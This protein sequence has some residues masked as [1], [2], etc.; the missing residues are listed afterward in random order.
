MIDPAL[1]LLLGPPGAALVTGLACRR[2]AVLLWLGCLLV[3]VGS[4]LLVSPNLPLLR[5]IG[6]MLPYREYL[7]VLSLTAS[8]LPTGL[9]LLAAGLLRWGRARRERRRAAKGGSPPA[10]ASG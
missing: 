2:Y 9:I 1:W 10:G 3:V 5:D 8:V 4:L 6:Q 7:Q